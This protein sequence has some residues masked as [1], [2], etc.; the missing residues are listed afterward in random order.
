ML[1][2]EGSGGRWQLHEQLQSSYVVCADIG[3]V[4]VWGGALPQSQGRGRE[5]YSRYGEPCVMRPRDQ[6]EH[7]MESP[8][9]FLEQA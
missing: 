5:E 7:V 2:A 9:G 3:I 1:S 6:K 8:A 4:C